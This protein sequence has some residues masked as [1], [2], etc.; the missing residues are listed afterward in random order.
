MTK[1][2]PPLTKEE[3]QK[4][5]AKLYYRDL[6]PP[7]PKLI[8]ILD[9]GH[10]D[11]NKALPPDQI[12][13]LLDPGYD[14]VE[15]GYC[16]LENGTAYVAVNNIF[17]N[18]TVEMFKWFYAW[19]PLEDLRYKVWCPGEH[20]GISVRDEDEKKIKD[21]SV[22]IEEKTRDVVHYC[23]ENIGG[24]VQ[25]IVIY[26]MKPEAAGYDVKKLKNSPVK[27]LVCGYGVMENGATAIMTHTMREIENGVEFR[28]RFWLGYSLKDG[29]PVKTLPDGMKIP[30]GIAKGL[31][32]HNVV[33]YTNLAQILPE[34]YKQH[35]GTLH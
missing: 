5:Y 20:A 14:D 9:K 21:M 33:E 25:T 12:N 34:L 26:Y 27:F 31:A 3:E 10:M 4:P 23:K 22:P 24:G 11:C 17:P 16:V 35:G 2:L 19:K 13:R 18:C 8:A 29:K 28:T 7:N 6:P 30:E 32:Y 15:T 1:N